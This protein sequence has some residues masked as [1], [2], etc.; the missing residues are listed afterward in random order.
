MR[1]PSIGSVKSTQPS[2]KRFLSWTSSCVFV[3]ARRVHFVDEDECGHL[4]AIEQSPQRFGM[5]LD[6]V[7][8]G[9]DEDGV[10][11]HGER[12]FRFGGEVDVSRS[13]EQ[14][15]G[16]VGRGDD[17]RLGEDGDA[18][19]PFHGVRVEEGVAVVD[20]AEF[21][22]LAG[23]VQQRL[24]HVVLPASTCA[25]MP[26]TIR[27]M[28][29]P[30]FA[31]QWLAVQWT[32]KPPHRMKRREGLMVTPAGLEPATLRLEVTCSI[33]LSYGAKLV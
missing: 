16:E 9:D 21:A 22:Y 8:A 18:A 27:F 5:A 10:V 20:A 15:D 17:G 3:G 23:S 26:A 25:R 4:I 11:E 33:Q 13:I 29:S 1:S 2:E 32:G 24:R 19:L 6:A 12:T 31:S 14:G 28:V 7:R 30:I